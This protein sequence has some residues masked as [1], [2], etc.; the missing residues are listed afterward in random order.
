M[1]RLAIAASKIDLSRKKGT[2]PVYIPTINLHRLT[3]LVADNE[4]WRACLDRLDLLRIFTRVIDC[5]S[6]SKAA[7]T[8]QMPR[9]SVST[10][11]KQLE[12]RVGARLIHRTT[13]RVSPTQD[14][15]AFYERSM[16]VLGDYE[17]TES[18][19][20]QNA[21]G[22]HGK[23]RIN[24]PGRFGR[25]I[26]A[27]ALPDFFARYPGI[28]IEMGVTD[29]PVDLIEDGVDCA[30][31]VGPLG[32]SGLIARRL[33]DLD[34]LNCASPAYLKAHGT[35]LGIADLKHHLAVR[36]ASPSTG[37]IEDWEYVEHGKVR[38]LRV[39]GQV[40]VNNAEAYIA[41]CLAGLGLIQ[42]PAYDAHDHIAAGDLVEVMPELRAM[43]MPLSILYPHR[44]HLSRRL[45]AFIEWT[46]ALLQARVLNP[47]R[48][49]PGMRS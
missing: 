27:P 29:R 40:T 8:L 13:R 22:L 18:L 38:M 6:F 44:Q 43:P 5:A 25:L 4:Q 15:S 34:L 41:C 32:D 37:R 20:R 3:T 24:V 9:S 26:V 1:P 16:R 14:G 48:T 47:D 17:E 28:E 11:V 23:L 45:Q 19:F 7:D 10:A 33:G 35:P 31:R 39:A 12:A 42:V 30:V 2:L 49:A 46:V 21:S 36:Y